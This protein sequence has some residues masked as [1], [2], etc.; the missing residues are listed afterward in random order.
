[1]FFISFPVHTCVRDKECERPFFLVFPLFLFSGSGAKPIVVDCDNP[2]DG[3]VFRA[4][5]DDCTE[6]EEVEEEE[7]D[8]DEDEDEDDVVDVGVDV[9]VD[10]DDDDGGQGDGGVEVVGDDGSLRSA[11][12]SD[13]LLG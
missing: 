9:D 12:L 13:F 4:D 7:D 11:G 2:E 6:E 1:M 5:N 8:D 3:E 10:V